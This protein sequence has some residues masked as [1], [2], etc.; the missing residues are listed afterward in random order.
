MVL[1]EHIHM[2]VQLQY[3]LLH[4]HPSTLIILNSCYLSLVKPRQECPDDFLER[5]LPRQ[6]REESDRSQCRWWD[7]PSVTV[8]MAALA[9]EE[10]KNF[11]A[12]EMGLT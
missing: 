6:S 12:G 2:V 5:N 8:A 10:M 1:K 9:A 11:P 7:R 3:R 4:F